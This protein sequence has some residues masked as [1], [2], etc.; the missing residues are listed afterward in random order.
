MLIIA[1]KKK[2]FFHVIFKT[3]ILEEL[4]LIL[5]LK[6]QD[7]DVRSILTFTENG[8]WVYI[9]VANKFQYL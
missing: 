4:L 6:G 7:G 1:K 2:E 8:S 9:L 5:F 3:R